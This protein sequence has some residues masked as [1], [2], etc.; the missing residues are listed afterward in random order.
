MAATSA[1]SVWGRSIHPRRSSRSVT[2]V[3]AAVALALCAAAPATAQTK[4]AVLVGINLYEPASAGRTA[5]STP[6]EEN[7][8]P[9]SA[10]EA[11]GPLQN[12]EGPVNDVEALK[13][14]LLKRYGFE[15]KNVHVLEESSATRDNMLRAI[16]QYL[17]GEAAPGD[18]SVFFF[19]GHG[20]RRKNSFSKEPGNLDSTFVPAD[21]YKGVDDILS[22]R[23]AGLFNE[24]LNKKIVLTAIYDSCHSGGITRGLPR[25]GRARLVPY[26]PRDAKDAGDSGP[27]PQENGGLILTA[28]RSDELAREVDVPE[29]HG[30]FTAAL[31]DALNFLPTDVPASE[32]MRRVD[33]LMTVDGPQDQHAEILGSGN[34]SLFGPT[35]KSSGRIVLAVTRDNGD[36]TYELDGGRALRLGVDSEFVKKSAEKES[37]EVRLRLTKVEGL[38]ASTAELA[39]GERSAVKQGDLFELVKWVVP[40]EARLKVWIPKALPP[41]QLAQLAEE[42]AKL[43]QSG[44]VEWVAD[45]VLSS[46]SYFLEWGET[47][48]TLRSKTKTKRGELVEESWKSEPLGEQ[49]TAAGVLAHLPSNAAEKPKVFA[50]LPPSTEL[51]N[52]LKLGAGTYNSAVEPVKMAD[53]Q[54]ILTGR[55][56]EKGIEYAWVQPGAV[57]EVSLQVAA[58]DARGRPTPFC[59]ASSPLPLRTNW[60]SPG[61]NKDSLEAAARDLERFSSQLGAIAALHKLKPSDAEGEFPYQ[62]ALKRVADGAIVRDGKL[63]QDEVYDLTLLADRAKLSPGNKRQFVYIF[64]MDCSGGAHLWF[65]SSGTSGEQNRLPFFGPGEYEWP[66]EI[67]LHLR[68]RIKIAAPYG[69]DTYFLVTSA[70]KI[71][72]LSVFEFKPVVT[73]TAGRAPANSVASIFRGMA[74]PTRGNGYANSTDWSVQRLTFQSVPK[75]IAAAPESK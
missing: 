20:S 27:P 37:A 2:W 18:I 22:K 50:L 53:A 28:A 24:I 32:V 60:I 66:T 52:E 58:A 4:R 5:Q 33:A 61:A 55:L 41:A 63:V 51:A 8:N 46:P 73:R 56:G 54:Y 13:Q 7:P 57:R 64:V 21:S 67:P 47:G 68:P 3:G 6:L 29:H 9:K 35:S 62:L 75:S 36:G 40:E 12:L 71:M 49:L 72:D 43:R 44:S 74:S 34:R 17:L 42:L 65:P 30:V 48:L 69:Q 70:E 45:P 19:A 1:P 59:S 25:P 10:R 14:I 15:P 16:R 26:D 11:R 31:I 39:S 23:V 38:S